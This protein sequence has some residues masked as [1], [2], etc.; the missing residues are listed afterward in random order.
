MRNLLSTFCLSAAVAITVAAVGPSLAAVP[1]RVIEEWRDKAQEVVDITVIS[2]QTVPLMRPSEMCSGGSETTTKV[3]LTAQVDVVH[4]TTTGLTRGA[5]IILQYAARRYDPPTLGC[6][7]PDGNYG[8][9]L[10]IGERATAYLKKVDEN[11]FELAG[12]VG[13]LVKL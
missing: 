7:P 6:I 11:A 1:W 13:C 2:V 4:R 9:F 12:D 8:V 10:G 5:T 3:T